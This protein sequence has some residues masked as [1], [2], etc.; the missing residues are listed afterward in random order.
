MVF[1]GKKQ[2]VPPGKPL[3]GTTVELA[4]GDY[5]VRVNGSERKVTIQVGK[6]TTLLTGEL[7]VEAEKGTPGFYIPFKG[8]ER[9]LASNPPVV[10][11][12]IALFA[13]KYEVVW[14]EG[15]VGKR[16]DLGQ[17]DVKAGMRTVRKK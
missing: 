13:G 9:M 5:V 3:L 1:Q 7:F 16:Q 14:Y 6:R 2:L 10:N 12:P 17:V 4:P 8:K 11:S 15:G